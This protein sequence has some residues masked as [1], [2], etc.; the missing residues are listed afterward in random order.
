ME[1]PQYFQAYIC[2][3]GLWNNNYRFVSRSLLHQLAFTAIRVKHRG[4][5]SVTL[6]ITVSVLPTI[7]GLR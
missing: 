4:T 5:G 7:I 3:C 6:T 2:V 1:H